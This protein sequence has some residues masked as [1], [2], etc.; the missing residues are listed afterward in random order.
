MPTDYLP[1]KTNQLLIRITCL[2]W[3]AAKIISWKLWLADRLFP[4]VPPFHFL[5]AP[6]AAHLLLL[7]FSLIALVLLMVYPSN[8]KLTVLLVAFE[9]ITCLF[10]QNRWQS[11]EYQYIFILLIILINRANMERVAGVF[12]FMIVAIYFYSGLGKIN[13]AFVQ[14]VWHKL[15]YIQTFHFL[16]VHP[17]GYRILYFVGIT[18]ALLGIG[19]L[20]KRTQKSAAIVLIG[21]HLAILCILSPLGLN[22]NQVVWPWNIAMIGYLLL[23][24]RMDTV[25]VQSVLSGWNKLILVVLGILPLLNF[26][27]W[28]DYYL[29][30]SLYSCRPPAM[31]ICVPKKAANQFLLAYAIDPKSIPHDSNTMVIMTTYWS[32][33]ELNVPVYPQ[34][35]VYKDI[36]QQLMQKY[37][38]IGDQFFVYYYSKGKAIQMS[39]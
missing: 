16:T 7:L 1:T 8:T 6:P 18:E 2:F 26:F 30:S 39:K 23:L 27:G 17:F 24:I 19:L 5:V 34:L 36:R 31:Y 25:T 28:W 38:E 22:S 20:F 14:F 12:R 37:P 35:R 11:W 3:L 33:K 4:L 21:M 29:S 13:G 10:D 32:Y 15:N 9:L